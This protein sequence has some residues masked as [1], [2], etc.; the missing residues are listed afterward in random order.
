MTWNLKG[1]IEEMAEYVKS[2]DE[3][4]LL[5]VGLEGFYGESTPERKKFNIVYEMG[6]DF[7]RNNLVE[8]IDFATVHVY[9]D[10]W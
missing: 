4:H 5:E 1:W 9:P 10:E 6:T 7:I 8:G 2:I 3:N